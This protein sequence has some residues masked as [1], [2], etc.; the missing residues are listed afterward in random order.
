MVGSPCDKAEEVVI[1][2]YEYRRKY[3]LAKDKVLVLSKTVSLQNDELYT[4]KKY[5]SE[6]S[7]HPMAPM[8]T[9][10]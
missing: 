6:W 7:F 2:L 1:E 3:K 10:I 4:E 8:L 9:Y 5:E